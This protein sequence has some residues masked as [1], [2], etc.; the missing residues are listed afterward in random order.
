MLPAHAAQIRGFGSA[1]PG[2]CSG[3]ARLCAAGRLVLLLFVLVV[4]CGVPATHRRVEI[5]LIYPETALVLAPS[6]SVA[7]KAQNFG[8]SF[9]Q[10]RKG[11]VQPLPTPWEL[12]EQCER[13]G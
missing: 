3:A 12:K 8:L 9:V 1:V 13:L 6:P 10:H 2:G 5:P 7:A 11:I 4:F